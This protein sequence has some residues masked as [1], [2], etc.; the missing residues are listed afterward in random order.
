MGVK[1]N[2]LIIY[3]LSENA[4]TIEFGNTIN[5]TAIGRVMAFDRQ[6]TNKPFA[7]MYQ[8]VP[9]YATLTVFFDPMEIVYQNELPGK[10]C[11]EKVSGYL[12]GLTDE[13]NPGLKVENDMITIPVCYGGKFGTD[14]EYFTETN[15]LTVDEVI[16][17]HS[18]SIYKVCMIGF[19]PGFTYLGGLNPALEIPRKDTPVKVM[20]GSV[21]IGGTQTGI[22]PLETPGGWQIIGRT[23]L[24]MF[25]ARRQQPSLL[26][27]GDRVKFEP[28]NFSDFEQYRSEG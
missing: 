19:I 21:G 6:L 7:G 25:D 27:T 10:S 13:H 5:E 22:Y 20:P 14:M 28:I 2:D 16:R 9:A 8:T 1:A 17:M 4:V 12:K 3:P 18:E 26:K 11:F 24:R 23:P 15:R